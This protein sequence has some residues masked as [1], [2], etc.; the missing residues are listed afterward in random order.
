M[1]LTYCGKIALIHLFLQVP[2]EISKS[3]IITGEKIG[4][5]F[6]GIVTRG[7]VRKTGDPLKT[8]SCVFSS[9]SLSRMFYSSL[10]RKQA[11]LADTSVDIAIKTVKDPIHVKALL[12]EAVVMAQ[13]DHPNLVFRCGFRFHSFLQ[14]RMLSL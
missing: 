9:S 7:K 6:F 4:Q 13:L 11:K 1:L 12:E 14:M 10:A 2:L 8:C 5:E 3:C